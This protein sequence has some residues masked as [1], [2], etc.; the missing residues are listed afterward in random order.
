[1]FKTE[2]LD[3]EL[4]KNLEVAV[5]DTV[6]FDNDSVNPDK[7]W[8]YVNHI[9]M[10]FPELYTHRKESLEVSE[11]QQI[12]P[13]DE[14]QLNWIQESHDSPVAGYPEQAN[15]YDLLSQN[16]SQN[17]M[18]KNMAHYV[19]NCHTCQRSK[20]THGT[21]HGSL[22]L[23]QVLEQPWKDLSMDFW[24]GCQKEKDSTQYG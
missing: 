19:Q 14:D 16:H 1:M 17:Q 5:M 22:R 7:L 21:T 4:R 2:N 3:K 23:F 10:Q 20:A 9:Y 18:R 13:T 6:H 8:N 12:Q 24:L 15:T 11:L